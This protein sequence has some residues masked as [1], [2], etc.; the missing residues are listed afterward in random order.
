MPIPEPEP[1][2]IPEPKLLWPGD[3][4]EPIERLPNIPDDDDPEL[5]PYWAQTAAGLATK[6]ATTIA[7][8]VPRVMPMQFRTRTQ[9]G[10]GLASATRRA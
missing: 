8:R 7:R 10:I 6:P 3:I 2:P 5:L 9:T 1:M 4:P